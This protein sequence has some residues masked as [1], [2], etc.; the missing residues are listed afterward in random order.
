MSLHTGMKLLGL[1]NVYMDTGCPLGVIPIV[2]MEKLRLNKL[3]EVT[4]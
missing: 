1:S 2:E 4:W 3:S